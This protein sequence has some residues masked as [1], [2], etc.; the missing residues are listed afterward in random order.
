VVLCVPV[1]LLVFAGAFLTL[2]Q[3]IP[4][5][6]EALAEISDPQPKPIPAEGIEHLPL[7][8][9]LE[10]HSPDRERR[11]YGEGSFWEIAVFRVENWLLGLWFLGLY[12]GWR[13]LGL[14]LIGMSLFK[15][16]RLVR[17]AE[18]WKSFRKVGLAGFA[19]GIPLQVAS[20]VLSITG[21]GRAAGTCLAEGLQYAGSLGI[22]AGYMSLVAWLFIKVRQSAWQDRFAAVG[23]T[24]L[25][26]YI[27]QSLLCSLL[28]CS[29]GLG[30]FHQL[31]RLQLWLIVPAVWAVQLAISPWWLKRFRFG[32]LE[33]LW[34]MLT[35]GQWISIRRS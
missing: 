3:D 31:D 6:R 17:P 29:Y 20:L 22:S 27:L 4:E 18:H 11:I 28:F 32:P 35:Y 26:N 19:V 10:Y 33:W 23:Q 24:A 30:L 25:S 7:L 15:S 16:G 13:T 14:F 8:E 34:R 2:T 5:V 9:R 12:F 21:A 1:V